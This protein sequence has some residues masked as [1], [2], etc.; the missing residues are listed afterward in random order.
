M[1]WVCHLEIER[2]RTTVTP[3][4]LIDTVDIRASLLIL[5]TFCTIQFVEKPSITDK[6]QVVVLGIA[7]PYQMTWFHHI[8]SARINDFELS[9][10]ISDIFVVVLTDNF[11]FKRYG[12]KFCR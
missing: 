2:A 12:S 8:V 10:Y 9:G 4:T 3:L 11:L 1:I 7:F 5:D 6:Q